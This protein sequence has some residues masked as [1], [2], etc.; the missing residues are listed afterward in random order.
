M[1]LRG[2]SWRS[3]ASKTKAFPS[4]TW[5]RGHIDATSRCSPLEAGFGEVDVVL[6]AAEN[7]VIDGV[8]V[9]Q[10]DDG[11]AF[12]LQGFAGQLLEVLRV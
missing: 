3:T 9:A 6:D 5:E 1:T 12:G 10:A 2:G 4:T 8:F 7:F 11:F